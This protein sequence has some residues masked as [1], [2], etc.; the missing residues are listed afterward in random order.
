MYNSP[1]RNAEKYF[2]YSPDLMISLSR[3]SETK[4]IRYHG[5]GDDFLSN[6]ILTNTIGKISLPENKSTVIKE[7]RS[8]SSKAIEKYS[9]FVMRPIPKFNEFRNSNNVDATLSVTEN[10]NINKQLLEEAQPHKAG[11]SFKIN[12]SIMGNSLTLKKEPTERLLGNK[13]QNVNTADNAGTKK[14]E[15]PGYKPTVKRSKKDKRIGIELIEDRNLI[16]KYD[17]NIYF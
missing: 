10:L 12:S 16:S 11:P 13:R 17:C 8:K 1:D 9:N 14:L 7:N 3:Y 6:N 5:I 2:W 4:G 15:Y